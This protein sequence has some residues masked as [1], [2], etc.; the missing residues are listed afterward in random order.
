MFFSFNINLTN[1]K[2]TL[3]LSSTDLLEVKFNNFDG[4]RLNRG[5]VNFS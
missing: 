2:T 4:F 5:Y 1:C 3:V